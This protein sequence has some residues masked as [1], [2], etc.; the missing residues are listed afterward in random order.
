MCPYCCRC[1]KQQ[2]LYM[3]MPSKTVKDS[4]DMSTIPS[5]KTQTTGPT[6][7]MIV[8]YMAMQY[9]II[10]AMQIIMEES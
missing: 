4:M 3:Q 10:M 6:Y 1:G 5:L 8:I 7:R 2:A 9:R